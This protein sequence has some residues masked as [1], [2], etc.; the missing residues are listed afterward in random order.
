MLYLYLL[1]GNQ[2]PTQKIMQQILNQYRLRFGDV[3]ILGGQRHD[4]PL[5]TEPDIFVVST[6]LLV[7]RR[8][9]E[10]DRVCSSQVSH[11]A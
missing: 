2:A 3:T 10:C 1:R 8:L 9:R 5:P 6:C 11:R 4:G 7:L